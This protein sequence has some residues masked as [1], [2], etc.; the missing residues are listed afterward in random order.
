MTDQRSFRFG[1]YA[2]PE[3]RQELLSQA[4]AAESLG[5]DTF[6]MADHLNEQLATFPALT[7]VAENTGMRIGTYVR[8]GSL[9]HP[10]VMA[11]EAATLDLLSEGRFELGLGAGYLQVD[12]EG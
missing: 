8:C 11:K 9:R 7:T 2:G 12:Y 6:L 10:V 5:Y 3:T 4:H 1:V